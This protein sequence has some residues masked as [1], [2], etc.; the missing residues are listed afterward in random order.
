MGLW[1]WIRGHI[2]P[3][4]KSTVEERH[5]PDIL[6]LVALVQCLILWELEL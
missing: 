6:R 3:D 2:S 1:R 4:P 5:H